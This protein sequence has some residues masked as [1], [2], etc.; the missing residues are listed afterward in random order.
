M[1]LHQNI[2]CVAAHRAAVLSGGA[3][4]RRLAAACA[5]SASRATLDVV[6]PLLLLLYVIYIITIVLFDLFL[7]F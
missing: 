4:T 5:T 2:R 1:L 6:L 7:C 3:M